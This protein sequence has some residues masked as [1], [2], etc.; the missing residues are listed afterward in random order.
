MTGGTEW[1]RLDA[2]LDEALALAPS[3]RRAFLEACGRD[4]PRTRE[5]LEEL[6][7]IAESDDPQLRPG[8]AL[9]GELADE[10]LDDLAQG[11]LVLG[12]GARLGRFEITGLLGRGGSG[13]VYRALDPTLGREIAIKALSGELRS[14]PQALG[15]FEREARA[16]ATV[17]HA[18][19]AQVLGLETI[20]GHPYLL[21][22]L[23]PGETLEERLGR[24]AVPWRE[25]AALG[26]QMAEALAEMHTKGI[27]HRDL[28]PGNVKVHDGRVK[29]LDFGLARKTPALV[30][31]TDSLTA[32]TATLPGRVWGTLHSMSPEQARGASVDARTDIWALGC[33]LYEMVS[34]RRAFPGDTVAD[35]LTAVIRDDPDWGALPQDAPEGLRRLLA[36]CLRRDVRQRMQHAGDVRI[37]LG[38]LLAA[39]PSAAAPRAGGRRRVA[40]WLV[41]AAAVGAAATALLLPRANDAPLSTRPLLVTLDPPSGLRLPEDYAAFFALSPDGTMLA[42][43]AEGSDGE[44]RL[45]LRALDALDA[46]EVPG[47]EGSWQPFF[48]PDGRWLAFFAGRKLQKAAVSGGAPVP[49][50]EVGNNPRGATWTPDGHIVL[51]ASQSSGLSRVSAEGG[52]LEEL[53]RPVAER[54]ERSHRWPHALADGSAVLFTA[55]QEGSTFDEASIEAVSLATRERKVVWRGGSHARALGDRLLFAQAGRLFAVGFDAKKLQATGRPAAVLDGVHYEAQNGGTLM[56]VSPDG[57]LVYVPG[58]ATPPDRHIA[59]LDRDGRIERLAGEPRFFHDIRLDARGERVAAQV[60]PTGSGDLFVQDVTRAAISQVTHGQRP[61]R[62]VWSR[63][64][65]RVVVGAPAAQGW[66]LVSLPIPSGP[67]TVLHTSTRRLYPGDHS[68]DSRT[69]VFQE[70]VPGRGWDL[71]AIDLDAAGR[72]AGPA[73]DLVATPAHEGNA[74]FSPDGRW[75]AYECD[76]VDAVFDVYVAP[77]AHEA[78]TVRVSADSGRWPVWGGPGELFYWIGLPAGLRHVRWREAEERFVVEA[79]RPL[80]TAPPAARTGGL[81]IGAD[82]GMDYAPSGRLLILDES[83][84]DRPAPAYRMTLFVGWGDEVDRRLRAGR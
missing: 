72:P 32:A 82:A 65:R 57:T 68:P 4:D 83:R 45:Y 76:A 80:V 33:V 2:L 23:V 75:I 58:A 54:G 30:D 21:L 84:P 59:W 24:G 26:Q 52:P 66:Q 50:V 1:A 5:R 49:I 17:N 39:L 13:Q 63:D 15:R 64:G 19:V 43:L 18:N 42:F 11:E 81:I 69:L 79:D 9:E 40:P 28:K 51:A 67:P 41:G 56:A 55:D 44:R 46:R 71:R 3:E 61:R 73:R 78:A 38:E 34:G 6:L 7:R 10:V 35:V 31:A 14:D 70:L 22:E 16:L 53:T 8:G 29:V 37:E 12:P 77:F 20:E 60:G 48:S 47:S 36:R 27:V 25:T 62:P 74:R